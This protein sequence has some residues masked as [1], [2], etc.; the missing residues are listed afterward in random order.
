VSEI[1]PIKTQFTIGETRSKLERWNKIA[2]ES[3]KQSGR[4]RIPRV[5]EELDFADACKRISGFDWAMIP[6][7][8]ANQMGNG[9]WEM[10][11]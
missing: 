9:K 5:I 1:C 7:E 10:G 6:Y 11:G 3:A 4:G 2:E 8:K